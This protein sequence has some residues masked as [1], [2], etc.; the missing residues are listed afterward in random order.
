VGRGLAHTADANRSLAVE[1][2]ADLKLA[3]YRFHIHNATG[4]LAT[5]AREDLP[6]RLLPSLR[7]QAAQE[8]N[9]LRND[10]LTPTRRDRS[11]ADTDVALVDVVTEATKGFGHLPLDLRIALGRGVYLNREQSMV[12]ETALIAL[13]YNV[14]FYAHPNE[15]VV[16][17]DS[18]SK[19]WEVSVADDGVGFD[20]ADQSNY[21]FGLRS[22]VLDSTQRAGMEVEVVSRPGE[23]TCVYIRGLRR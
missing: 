2:E 18:T 8:A 22:Q 6:P 11:L 13:L 10:I 21:G 23:G 20:A 1:L 17:A 12:L 16:H 15:V 5:L 14:Q 7:I 19:T 4:L 9:R 3:S